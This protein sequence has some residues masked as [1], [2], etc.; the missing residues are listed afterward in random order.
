MDDKKLSVGIILDFN[1]KWFGGLN[2]ILNTIRTLK[3][4]KPSEQPHI[5]VLYS[6]NNA[7]FLKEIK[8]AEYPKIEF[9]EIKFKKFKKAFYFFSFLLQENLFF[10]SEMREYDFIFPLNDLP[11]KTKSKSTIICSWIPDFQHKFYPQNFTFWRIFFREMRFKLIFK[12]TDYTV[13]S[14]E[15]AKNHLNQ[16][17]KADLNKTKVIPFV[18]FISKIS[19]AKNKKVLNRFNINSP[20]FLISNQFYEHKNHLLVLRAIV[21]VKVQFPDLLFVFTGLMDSQ[22][23]NYIKKFNEFLKENNLDNN[24]LFTGF[25]ERNDQISLMMESKAIIQPSKFEGWNTSIEDAKTLGIDIIASDLKVHQEQLGKHTSYFNYDD[26]YELA[27]LILLKMKGVRISNYRFNF[28]KSAQTISKKFNE[29]FS[30]I[31]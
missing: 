16:F 6:R 19:K 14:S 11:I 13:L 20:F 24:C 28:E 17:Y 4:L 27:N 10:T 26:H 31:N 7:F 8:A 1:N 9:K 5:T 2:Y 29:L 18:S 12:N 21:S 22:K 3:L 25:I 23:N 30:H 15:N